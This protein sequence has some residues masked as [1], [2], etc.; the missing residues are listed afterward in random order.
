MECSAE[1][2]FSVLFIVY[3]TLILDAII[4][5]HSSGQSLHTSIQMIVKCI[6]LFFFDNFLCSPSSVMSF[7]WP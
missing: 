1:V 6:I 3:L 2:E 7:V 5:S 4:N